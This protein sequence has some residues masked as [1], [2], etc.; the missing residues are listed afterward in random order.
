MVPV[1]HGLPPGLHAAPV[2][3]GLHV[4]LSHTSLVP[5]GVP[6]VTVPVGEHV[7]T[8]VEH[9][10]EPVAHALPPG[11]HDTPAVHAT[12]VPLLQTMFRP[13][14]VPS[15]ALLPVSSHEIPASEQVIEPVLHGAVVGAHAA[16]FV[17]GWHEPFSQ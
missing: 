16:P 2:A 15:G 8:P 6:L 11:A 7:C 17:H 12:H 14:D 3:H 10:V 13:H 5:Q 9:D 1:R 4:P